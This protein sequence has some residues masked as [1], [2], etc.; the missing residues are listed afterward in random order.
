[1]TGLRREDK[2]GDIERSPE[3]ESLF[4]VLKRIDYRLTHILISAFREYFSPHNWKILLFMVLS[5]I[6]AAVCHAF[7]ISS[8]V[9]SVDSREILIS[10][11]V[12]TQEGLG[13]DFIVLPLSILVTLN[14]GLILMKC[15]GYVMKNKDLIIDF[16]IFFMTITRKVLDFRKL[17]YIITV[18]L[19]IL[20]SY[21]YRPLPV[22]SYES[23]LLLLF[24]FL[25][26]FLDFVGKPFNRIIILPYLLLL[27]ILFFMLSYQSFLPGEIFN[28]GISYFHFFLARIGVSSLYI[29]PYNFFFFFPLIIGL[30]FSDFR[31]LEKY[32]SSFF[33]AVSH[34]HMIAVLV[35]LLL[36]TM[37]S[38]TSFFVVVSQL[39][40][41]FVPHSLPI[42]IFGRIVTALR[43]I[44]NGINIE[45]LGAFQ[46]LT[47]TQLW[48]GSFISWFG[49]FFVGLMKIE[50]EYGVHFNQKL[51]EII[52][53]IRNHVVII[54]F[55]GLGK[56]ICTDLFERGAISFEYDTIEILTPDLN[57]ERI[58]YKILIVDANSKLF[59]R[60][61]TSSILQNI[62][63]AT[64]RIEVAGKKKDILLP[65][66]IGDINSETTRKNS[67]IG[68]SK[69]LIFTLS[70]YEPSLTLLRLVDS[71][72]LNSII[73]V[74]G[75][76]QKD[77]FS[78]KM[79]G[80]NTFFVYPAL[81][82]GIALG[83]VTSLCYFR[84]KEELPEEES[85]R[86]EI[87]I[88]GEGKQIHYLMETFWMEMERAG[89]AKPWTKRIGD[90]KTCNPPISVLTDSKEIERRSRS[91]RGEYENMRELREIIKRSSRKEEDDAYLSVDVILETPDRLKTIERII[92]DKEP[93][94]IVVTSNTLQK[95]SKIFHEWVV[96]VERHVSSKN[97]DYK[98][99][100]IVGVLGD[101]YEEIQ[102]TL[103]YYT[104]MDPESGDKFPIQYLDAAVRAYDDSKEQIGGL[105]QSFTRKDGSLVHN[106]KK[107]GKIKDPLALY[108]CMEDVPGSLGNLLGRLAGVQFEPVNLSN[109]EDLVSL[110]FCRFQMCSGVE[111]YSF[112]ANA[113]LNKGSEINGEGR[114]LS[115]VYQSESEHPEKARESLTSLLDIKTIDSDL[116]QLR[117]VCD[118]C[119][120]RIT[121]SI[122]SYLRK[123]ENLIKNKEYYK[124]LEVI[125]KLPGVVERELNRFFVNQNVQ[126]IDVEREQDNQNLPKAAILVC[127]R[128]SQVTGSL[129]TAVNNLLF[130]QIEKISDEN[131]VAD[132]TYLRSFECYN[133]VLT[134]IELYGNWV[135]TCKGERELLKKKGSI[136]SVFISAA[137]KKDAW[138]NYA[139]K[140]CEV[141]NE[142]YQNEEYDENEIYG[143]WADAERNNI[144][145]IRNGFIKKDDKPCLTC[146][147]QGCILHNKVRL[148][149]ET[150]PDNVDEYLSKFDPSMQEMANKLRRII[151]GTVSG[152][153]EVATWGG[154]LYRKNEYVCAVVIHKSHVGLHFWR[155]RELKDPK[156]LL[157]GTGE[158]KRHIK[159]GTCADIKV[160][161]IRELI[162]QAVA[163]SKS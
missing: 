163:L 153:E 131:L 32:L 44:F 24:I 124:Y 125:K 140:L 38:F 133:P 102:D 11:V 103:L 47:L 48:I 21:F 84:L 130:R 147:K 35:G 18:F 137:T 46:T 162:E 83:R 114:L 123:M 75:S 73:S 9:L 91:K 17:V 15:I 89:V 85:K 8:R 145:V 31:Y 66:I 136:D 161:L 155:G 63:I 87:V 86:S 62:G 108:C 78:P 121:C 120:R 72:D 43:E 118:R 20:I 151:L 116:S 79:T 113:E 96:G 77:F 50:T 132:I 53:K 107:I 139:K 27:N 7:Y 56:E 5:V 74:E 58:C 95:V 12:Y 13:Y 28:S 138:F 104:K 4:S 2:V 160:D 14:I 52:Q 30:Y 37:F 25:V 65:V 68:R 70:G 105:A 149:K 61:H 19:I 54:G 6:P 101:E 115:C 26:I 57:V 40:P 112:L 64:S 100:I 16:E 55:E 42:G 159:I 49:P 60:V 135:D 129:S 69:L 148:L 33:D 82:E 22:S 94:I 92:E 23:L 111:N 150:E 36:Y 80:H 59:G 41:S 29:I 127:C 97:R 71:G 143:L 146:E 154:I 98:P 122:A 157:E 51:E 99:V 156:H 119:N 109:I 152:M 45:D 110:H 76:A 134:N 106:K 1:M 142:M 3:E 93:Q 81:Q 141:L 39:P 67:Q 34:E 144:A 117:D 158:D 88:V 90:Q 126:R 10:R 128:H